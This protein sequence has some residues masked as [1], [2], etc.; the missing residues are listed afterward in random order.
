MGWYIRKPFKL[1]SLLRL[2]LSKSGIGYS[3]GVKGA[4]IGSGPRGNYVHVGRH[5]LYYRQSL[6]PY[7]SAALSP[8]RGAS[9]SAEEMP[10][11]IQ[12]VDPS[13]LEDHSAQGVL[14]EIQRKH[15]MLR[16]T[17]AVAWSSGA[18]FGIL[19]LQ[20]ASIW[21]LALVLL[22]GVAL[23]VVARRWD[24]ERKTVVLHFYLDDSAKAKYGY[25]L[26]AVGALSSCL[27]LWRVRAEQYV[28]D[29]KYNAGAGRKISRKAVTVRMKSPPFVQTE[30]QVWS[31]NLGDQALYL[32]PD[33]V[34]VYQGRKVGAVPYSDLKLLVVPTQ[35]VEDSS[36]PSDTVV[37]GRRWQYTNRNGGPDR[38][39]S[40]NP[41]M[42]VVQY[43]EVEINSSTGMHIV[44]Q[45][46]SVPKATA[47]ANGI[48]QYR[49]T[50]SNPAG[51]EN[52]EPSE[53]L[54][55]SHQDSGARSERALPNIA[56]N[57]TRK[58]ETMFCA[59]CGAKN[60]GDARFCNQCGKALVNSSPAGS[61]VPASSAAKTESQEMQQGSAAQAVAGTD[62]ATS[63]VLVEIQ[64][65]RFQKGEY[66]KYL[67]WDATYSSAGLTKET[68]AIK[69]VMEFAD[70]FGEVQFRLKVVINDPMQPGKS[71][72]APGIGFSINEFMQA[73]RWMLTTDVSDMSVKFR[74]E[75]IIYTDGTK[76]TL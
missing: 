50:S 25:L 71:L 19:T 76:E 13:A 9:V 49:R 15:A 21:L 59:S 69:G 5:G 42:P 26:S 67:W 44:L 3:F 6:P 18:L 37:V 43:A 1:G 65:K 56:L 40:N 28:R 52:A 74:I 51:F 8:P 16:L 61:A 33:R 39:F 45:A 41:Q 54:G 38:R 27:G 23:S 10:H 29:V 58:E 48:D 30:V 35:F 72:N 47:F 36:V 17:P 53:T 55:S 31:I 60:S 68:R 14:S 62:R 73:H 70:L 66:E 4:R 34:L 2:N 32:F 46:S 24:K 20:Q 64:N 63:M 7:K 75:S 11:E 12:T 22:V 57:E